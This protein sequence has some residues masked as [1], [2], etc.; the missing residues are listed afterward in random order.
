MAGGGGRQ[1]HDR[2]LV[3]VAVQFMRL[4]GVTCLEELSSA[5]DTTG[6]SAIGAQH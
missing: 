6:G 1:P 3:W 4:L 2:D 5:R